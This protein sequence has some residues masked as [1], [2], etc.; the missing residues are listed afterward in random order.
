MSTQ[1]TDAPTP[2]ASYIQPSVRACSI[3]RWISACFYAMPISH[4]TM[5]YF[6][7]C[8]I[9]GTLRNTE[10]PQR[11]WQSSVSQSRAQLCAIA[12]T[13]RSMR[14]HVRLARPRLSMASDDNRPPLRRG[15]PRTR[16]SG[17][18]LCLGICSQNWGKCSIW[19]CD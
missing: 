7:H 17:R 2:N 1:A 10:G 14:G 4:V 3:N 5:S 8:E 18:L 15:S 19:R 12:R 9:Y 6:Q 16:Y 11:S 13:M